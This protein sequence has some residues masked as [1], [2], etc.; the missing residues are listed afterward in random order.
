MDVHR[1]DGVLGV[2]VIYCH[3]RR[4]RAATVELA[5]TAALWLAPGDLLAGAWNSGVVPN[6]LR[7]IWIPRPP[8]FQFPSSH[9]RAL[10]SD[11]PGG[12]GTIPARHGRTL[13]LRAA[14]E[15]EPR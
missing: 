11:D 3:R 6:P 14:R 15:R 4:S 10:G 13:R 2:S 7:R 5:A 1:S 8:P 12:A 9:G